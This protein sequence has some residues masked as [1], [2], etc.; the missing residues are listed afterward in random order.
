MVFYIASGLDNFENVRIAAK[1]LTAMGHEHAYD[2]T[3]H[4]DV[5]TKG[6]DRLRQVAL[7]E[8]S[9]VLKSDLVL[10]LLPGYRGT[11]TELGLAIASSLS[12]P[13]KQVWLWSQTGEQFEP[14]E[15]TCAF[16]F[17]PNVKRFIGDFES[18]IE[19]LSKWGE[20]A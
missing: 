11:H 9:A 12:M 7:N 10:F 1:K 15:R 19:E 4:G 16:Y 3:L 8:S 14:D 18:V 20:T 17:H 6:P 13:D 5:R 2:W